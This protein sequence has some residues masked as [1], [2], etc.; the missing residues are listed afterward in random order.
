MS[1]C[2][3]CGY[4]CLQRPCEFGES[5]S[6]KKPACRYVKV[7]KKGN[8]FA[9][10][11]CRKYQEIQKTGRG[12]ISPA[13]GAGCSSTLFNERR[14]RVLTGIMRGDFDHPFDGVTRA[15]VSSLQQRRVGSLLSSSTETGGRD[16]DQS[17]AAGDCSG[18]D[19]KDAGKDRVE[20]SN[21][22]DVVR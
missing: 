4:C 18:K 20:K 8:G 17:R 1:R 2:I 14:D 12:E 19:Q 21:E 16:E 11:G 13:F 22:H 15:Y 10:F 9:I 6:D 7:I 5:I 3:G